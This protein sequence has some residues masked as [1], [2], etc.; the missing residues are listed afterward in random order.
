MVAISESH[1]FWFVVVSIPNRSH[2][3]AH[4]VN[5]DGGQIHLTK[6]AISYNAAKDLT[7]IIFNFPLLYS[8]FL[9]CVCILVYESVR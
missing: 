6:S 3:L 1:S 9:C 7:S 2:G 8:L 4:L 5:C